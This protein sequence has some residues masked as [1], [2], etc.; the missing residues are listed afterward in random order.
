MYNKLERFSVLKISEY[1]KSVHC[2]EPVQVGSGFTSKI[3]LAW[4]IA[5]DKH[6]SLFGTIVI[7]QFF[8]HFWDNLFSRNKHIIY[9]NCNAKC[10]IANG[11]AHRRVIQTQAYRGQLW[12]G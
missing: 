10:N 5:T 3:R 11:T 9:F 8:L 4:K 12:K 7:D 6:S 2:K 1:S